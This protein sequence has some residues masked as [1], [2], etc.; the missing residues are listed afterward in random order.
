MDHQ[1]K[2]L[3]RYRDLEAMG[4]GSR[5]TVWRGVQAGTFPS[6]HDNGNGNP[7]WFREDIKAWKASLPVFE[8]KEFNN[9][10]TAATA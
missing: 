4:Y 8:P 7:V 2:D 1:D 9:L 3:L 10:Q 6:P 5:T